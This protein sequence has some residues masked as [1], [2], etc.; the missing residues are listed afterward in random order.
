MRPGRVR[1]WDDWFHEVF[2]RGGLFSLRRMPKT[3]AEV[4]L[5]AAALAPPRGLTRLNLAVPDA[6]QRREPEPGDVL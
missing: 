4:N 1:S 3:A 5:E 6:T 2:L